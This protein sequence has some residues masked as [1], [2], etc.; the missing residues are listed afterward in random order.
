V[1][2]GAFGEGAR[3]LSS[4]HNLVYIHQSHEVER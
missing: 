3:Y 4:D 2:F 1:P